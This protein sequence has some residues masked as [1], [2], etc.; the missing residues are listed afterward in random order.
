MEFFYDKL[1]IE[2]TFDEKLPIMSDLYFQA[3]DGP[4]GEVLG[5]NQT[6]TKHEGSH[7]TILT[8]KIKDNR[9]L[10]DGNPSRYSRL[11]NLFGLKTLDECVALYNSI[12]TERG[13]PNFTKC[14]CIH[15]YQ[16]KDGEK[17]GTFSDGAVIKEVH[18]TQNRSVGK[19]NE[20]QYIKALAT[21]K[22]RYM[23]PRLHNNGKTVDWLT[24]NE[25]R[26]SRIYPSVY[27]KSFEM[28]LPDRALAKAKKTHGI[29]SKEYNYVKDVIN[30]CQQQGVVRFEL[31]LN[32]RVLKEMGA[33]YWGLFQDE[34]F[35]PLMNQFLSID[36]KLQVTAMT[37]E[38]IAETLIREGVCTGTYSANVTAMYAIQWAS[39]KEFNLEKS[40]VQEKRARLRKIGIDIGLPC[41]HSKFSPIRIREVR[42]VEVKDLQPP[43][44]YRKPMH[45]RLVA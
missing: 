34:I 40:A 9:I 33:R 4:S 1:K 24:K 36:S 11:E 29:D 43:S 19:G 6:P 3:I 16:G 10:M 15:Q 45:L 42:E 12:L 20:D 17:A 32:G 38:N 21:Q 27:N 44:F 30:Y 35:E 18:V 5:I 14:T 23:E 2:Q 37:L 8:I 28:T 7:S 13:L 25:S 22:W 26:S 39:G 41:D 31:K